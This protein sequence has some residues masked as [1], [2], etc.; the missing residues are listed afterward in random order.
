MKGVVWELYICTYGACASIHR[1]TDRQ[2][3]RQRDALR[4]AMAES[5]EDALLKEFFADV[6]E[7]ERDN[8]VLRF[9]ASHPFYRLQ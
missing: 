6:S 4:Q 5:A 7:V 9:V 3:D 1:Q 2:T 8:E